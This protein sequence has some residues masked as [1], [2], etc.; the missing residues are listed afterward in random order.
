MGDGDGEG[1]EDVTDELRFQ[2]AHHHMSGLR[3]RIKTA[4]HCSH[5]VFYLLVKEL[6]ACSTCTIGKSIGVM[7]EV[8]GE[9]LYKEVIVAVP[10]EDEGDF[11][12]IVICGNEVLHR[13]ANS[14]ENKKRDMKL[15]SQV[16]WSLH[17]HFISS[18]REVKEKFIMI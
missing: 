8:M 10:K 15:L 4:V 2:D 6:K 16:T 7:R 18:L 3:S 12:Y 13:V 11:G 1:E 9:N 5:W 14:M 17:S